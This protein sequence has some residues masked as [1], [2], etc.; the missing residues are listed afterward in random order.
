MIQCYE[1]EISVFFFFETQL[2]YGMVLW[3]LSYER[4]FY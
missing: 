3:N 2:C 1:V 4:L